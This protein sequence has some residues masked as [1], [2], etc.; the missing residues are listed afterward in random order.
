M[1]RSLGTAAAQGKRKTRELPDGELVLFGAKDSLVEEGIENP[2]PSLPSG[3]SPFGGEGVHSRRR[4]R[5]GGE[6]RD[7]RPAQIRNRFFQVATGGV[8]DS[9]N[10]VSVGNDPKVVR[11]NVLS[12]MTEREK[13]SGQ[14]L[15]E[16]PRV[17][18]GAGALE[19]RHLHRDGGSSRD[20]PATAEVLPEGAGHRDGVDA[21]MRPEA[22]VLENESR[23]DHSRG[24]LFERPVPEI[25]RFRGGHFAEK[26][27]LSVEEQVTRPRTFEPRAREREPDDPEAPE[28][29]D[30]RCPGRDTDRAP[31]HC[32][33][34]SILTRAPADCPLTAL[35]Y[36]IS[37][38]A[39]GCTKLPGVVALVRK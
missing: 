14:A 9:M 4:L 25:A 33:V 28:N 3:P 31:F 36:I 10:P 12:P 21:G 2:S 34:R 27:S 24:E 22:A 26:A 29:A 15:D 20:P 37:A 17:R 1:H 8:R 32:S 39:D 16:L 5:D 35:S 18:S 19:S 38:K 11:K 6:K 23:R 7:L 30:K 13:K